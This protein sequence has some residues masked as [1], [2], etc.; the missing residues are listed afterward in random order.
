MTLITSR[1]AP[2]R[3][4]DL[5]EP[6]PRHHAVITG[7][8]RA[9]TTFLVELLTL[10][11]LDTGFSSRDLVHRKSAVA[12]AG[13]E[14]DVR[15]QGAPYIVKAPAFCEHAAQVFARPDI[16]IDHVFVPMRA[17]HEAAESRR[18]VM[19]LHLA[20]MS[21]P[22]R[23]KVWL[24]RK[25][26]AGGLVGTRSGSDQE[27]VLR[28]RLYRL[29]LAAAEHPV[30]VTL[31]HFPRLVQDSAY[32][33]RKLRPLLQD[34]PFE[35]FDRVHRRLAQPDLVHSFALPPLQGER[36]VTTP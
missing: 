2:A 34:I 19:N 9:G 27:Q 13:L 1:P 36:L 24:K 3:A 31:L 32:L 17:L 26:L 12:Q 16:V 14:I 21:W 33:Y 30:N 11:G 15:R 29:M 7:T 22:R 6:L 28:D 18:R 10:L 8:G 5:P 23:L 4:A 20:D 25:E 35:R